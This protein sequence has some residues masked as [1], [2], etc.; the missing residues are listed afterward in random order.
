MTHGEEV[1]SDQFSAG[2][3]INIGWMCRQHLQELRGQPWGFGA[4]DFRRGHKVHLRSV[5]GRPEGG[6]SQVLTQDFPNFLFWEIT[7]NY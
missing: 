1:P 3:S 2:S 4:R 5:T 7:G 6:D